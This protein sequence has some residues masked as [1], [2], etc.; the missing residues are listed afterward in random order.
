MPAIVS[1]AT[2][3]RNRAALLARVITGI[4]RAEAAI[5]AKTVTAPLFTQLAKDSRALGDATGAV[6]ACRAAA[7]AP[8][9]VPRLRQRRSNTVATLILAEAS[10][11]KAWADRQ[12]R[13]WMRARAVIQDLHGD[14]AELDGLL[15][16]VIA[17]PPA[18]PLPGA[19]MTTRQPLAPA[20]G[21]VPGASI[22]PVG[23]I[24]LPVG[25]TTPAS[26]ADAIVDGGAAAAEATAT[27]LRR[28]KLWGWGGLAAA[29][30]VAFAVLRRR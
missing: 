14:I 15:A 23:P 9:D 5:S 12:W 30:L 21:A 26:E 7:P 28:R 4:A 17:N 2:L 16:K 11:S 20:Q 1:C 19:G 27:A 6:R 13:S 24:D 10:L 22:S 29:G 18:I 8:K 3:D 25:P